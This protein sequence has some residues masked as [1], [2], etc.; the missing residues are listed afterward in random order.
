MQAPVPQKPVS[1]AELG[2]LLRPKPAALLLILKA[3]GDAH[4]SLLAKKSSMSYVH[5]VGVLK[6][7]QENGIITT[8]ARGNKRIARLTEAGVAFVSALEELAKKAPSR[9]V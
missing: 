8:E 3:G 9:K 4:V 6:T 2:W 5:T 7:L 1:A